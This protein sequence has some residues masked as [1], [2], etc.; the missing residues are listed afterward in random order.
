MPQEK[1]SF[2]PLALV[3]TVVAALVRLIPH[4]WNFAPIGGMALFGGSRLRGW[5]AFGIPLL[6]MIV[7]DPIISHMMGYPAYSKA[8]AGDLPFVFDLRNVGPG[9]SKR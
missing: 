1:T 6:A 4:P 7:T 8:Y 3:L 5:Q 9:V 2:Q